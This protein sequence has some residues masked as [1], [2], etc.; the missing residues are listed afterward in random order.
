MKDPNLRRCGHAARGVWMD[1]LC[2]AF[3]C[4]ERGVLI[5]AGRPW[6]TKEVAAAVGGNADVALACIDELLAKGVAKTRADGAVYSKRMVEDE[7]RR[8]RE[9]ERKRQQRAIP[10][11]PQAELP[12]P[13]RASPAQK[14]TVR[15]LSDECPGDVPGLSRV[16]PGLVPALSQPSSSSSSVSLSRNEESEREQT[17]PHGSTSPVAAGSVVPPPGREGEGIVSPAETASHSGQSAISDQKSAIAE[18]SLSTVTTFFKQ[19]MQKTHSEARIDTSA[20]K[21][22]AYKLEGRGQVENWQALANAWIADERPDPKAP[23]P[24]VYTP[25]KPQPPRDPPAS[26][27]E[28]KSIVSQFRESLAYNLPN[29][30]QSRKDRDANQSRLC[31]SGG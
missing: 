7:A 17:A 11:D 21:F 25:P 9:T 23:K 2:L 12:S 22:H 27:E 15:P 4:D 29:K 20:A 14:E 1:V 16:C 26:S 3:E 13:S 8:Q 10:D 24:Y 30:P 28:I 19:R 31:R 6:T 18:I 5:T